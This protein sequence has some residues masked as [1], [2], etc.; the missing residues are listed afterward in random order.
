MEDL[1]KIEKWGI[2]AHERRCQQKLTR[3]VFAKHWAGRSQRTF[4]RSAP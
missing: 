3:H 2:Q 1:I 4:V